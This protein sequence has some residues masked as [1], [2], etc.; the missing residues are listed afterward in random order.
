[1][2]HIALLMMVK[3]EKKRLHVTLESVIGHVDSLIIYDTGSTDNTREIVREFSEK[4]KIP[5]NLI[6]G[7]F[8]DFATSRNVLLEEADRMSGVDFL[9]LMDTN[10]ELRGGKDL[11]KFCEQQMKTNET[12]Y[13]VNQEWFFGEN[14]FYYNIRLLKPNRTW[15]YQGVVHEWLQKQDQK[16]IYITHKVP[17]PVSLF[18]DRTQD[19]DK[20]GKRFHRDKD[21]LLAEFEKDPTNSRTVFYLAQTYSCLNRH[22]ES[23]HFYKIRADMPGF[24]EENFHCHLRM[25]DIAKEHAI[26]N[27]RYPQNRIPREDDTKEVSL[28][29]S[30]TWEIALGHYMKAFEHTPR[31]EPMIAVAEYYRSIDKWLL[32]YNFARIACE[33]DFPRDS[34]LFIDNRA[35]DYTRFHLLGIVA[36]YCNK[37]TEGYQA[38]QQA[39]KV[40]NKDIDKN[41]LKFYEDMLFPQKKKMARK[42][43]R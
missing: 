12:A 29:R 15:R 1:M 37:F 39:I 2:V 10:D 8:V 25:G 13:L 7:E 17:L 22:A 35:Y 26:I 24:Q 23:Y 30:F 20:T 40:A 43:R 19:D 41:N 6:E 42:G 31:A 32:S 33:L 36:F 21:L 27:N 16:D 38:C 28:L 18:Q 9:L 11:R 5:L 3:N 34:I 14:N 4:H